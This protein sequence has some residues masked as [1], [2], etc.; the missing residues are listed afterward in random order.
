MLSTGNKA[1]RAFKMAISLEEVR[2]RIL[3]ALFSDDELMDILVLKGGN[4]L[5]LVHKVGL[6]KAF[7]STSNTGVYSCAGPKLPNKP[8]RIVAGFWMAPSPTVQ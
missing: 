1:S 5:A 4:A 8:L 7:R 6:R 2:R 3:I